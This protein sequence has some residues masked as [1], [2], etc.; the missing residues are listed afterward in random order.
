MG[1]TGLYFKALLEGIAS[2]PEVPTSVSAHWQAECA[3]KGSP[4]LHRLL[5]LHDP[6]YAAKI[7]PNDRQR[8]PRALEVW[9]A[10]GKPFS[11]WHK[12]A[13]AS[14]SYR[15][16]KVGVSLPMADLE[17]VLKR[18]I[19]VM[20]EQGALEEAR[21]AMERCPN[22]AAP[23]WSGIGCREIWEYL[24]GACTLEE[25]QETWYRNTRAYAKR[26]NTWFRADPEITWFSPDQIEALVAHVLER[27]GKS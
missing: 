23:G 3:A 18:R 26:Q 6:E 5:A 17:P 27:L 20:L 12:E 8:I 7:H 13:Q 1:G 19:D 10:T 22:P 16:I 25:C 14:S 11:W 24:S 21:Q 2:I 9:Q 4:A 15:P